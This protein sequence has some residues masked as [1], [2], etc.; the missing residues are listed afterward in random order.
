MA[1]NSELF[2][3]HKGHFPHCLAKVDKIF[4]GYYCIQYMH[5]G[6]I[7]FQVD[8]K[9][10]KQSDRVLEG[11]VLWTTQPGPRYCFG[12]N[13]KKDHW[14]HRYIAFKGNK[15]MEWIERGLFPIDVTQVDS[16][17][18]IAPLLDEIFELSHAGNY[19][20]HLLAVNKLE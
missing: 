17:L 9:A 12:V 4:S 6:R 13:D 11:S 14:D 2:F 20:D 15:V 1:K 16:Q 8:S 18:A 19:Y 10:E 7:H 5:S 3:L